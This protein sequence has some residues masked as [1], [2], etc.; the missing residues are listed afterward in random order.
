VPVVVKTLLGT[1]IQQIGF[2][3]AYEKFDDLWF[4]VNYSGELKLRVLFVY[5]R[6]ISLGMINSDFKRADVKSRVT[7][8][9][10]TFEKTN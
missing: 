9:D 1:N 4:P 2:K 3:L 6:T 10:V 5:A 8:E 7:F